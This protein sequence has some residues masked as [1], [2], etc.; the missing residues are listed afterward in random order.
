MFGL[1][2][3]INLQQKAQICVYVK[4][5]QKKKS[6]TS[7]KNNNS[8][9][10][11]ILIFLHLIIFKS[12]D[13]P[14]SVKYDPQMRAEKIM[15]LTLMHRL[16]THIITTVNLCLQTLNHLIA[17][18]RCCKYSLKCNLV[19]KTSVHSTR[20]KFPLKESW[21]AITHHYYVTKIPGG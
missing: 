4:K 10:L 20:K 21:R 6:L 7:P 16:L 9:A 2:F 17:G 3:S 5:N 14:L 12:N 13:D 18:L 19:N 1:F 11:L 15:P 8:F